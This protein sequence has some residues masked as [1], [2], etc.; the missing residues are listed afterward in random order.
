MAQG[1]WN[2]L[3]RKFHWVTSR[4]LP[5]YYFPFSASCIY[6]WQAKTTARILSSCARTNLNGNEELEFHFSI[7]LFHMLQPRWRCCLFNADTKLP[8]QLKWQ[9]VRHPG[10]LHLFL[11]LHLLLRLLL[12]LL[13]VALFYFTCSSILFYMAPAMREISNLFF[14]PT[15]SPFSFLARFLLLLMSS[16]RLLV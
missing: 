12:P 16:S 11:F 13:L 7:V 1:K 15:L 6:Q 14:L 9:A 2:A 10:L 5:S 4:M 3:R 8:S